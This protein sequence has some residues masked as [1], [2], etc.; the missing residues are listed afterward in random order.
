MKRRDLAIS[1]VLLGGWSA[2]SVLGVGPLTVSTAHAAAS[3]QKP[4]I[5]EDAR[6]A[7]MRM[8]QTLRAGQFA[9]QA[10]TI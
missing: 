2:A 5:S 4:A 10:R 6:A 9:F 7:L 1:V 8:G 3:Q